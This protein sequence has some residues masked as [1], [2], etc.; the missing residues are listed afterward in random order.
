MR[1]P[2]CKML[3]TIQEQQVY[4]GPPVTIPVPLYQ[5]SYPGE[6]EYISPRCSYCFDKTLK[7]RSKDVYKRIDRFHAHL[8]VC[9]QCR[10]HPFGLCPTGARLLKE[11]ATGQ[12]DET[13]KQRSEGER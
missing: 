11:A 2:V 3:R 5:R 10:N 6:P 9:S 8:D 1:C 4:G 7:Q 12:C 13:Q